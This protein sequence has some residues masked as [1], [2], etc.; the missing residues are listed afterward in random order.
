MADPDVERSRDVIGR[1]A[2]RRS[3]P[4]LRL[5][6]AWTD[7]VVLSGIQHASV[8]K[9][10]LALADLEELPLRL[11]RRDATRSSTTWSSS[12]CCDASFERRSPRDERWRRSAPGAPT[13]TIYYTRGRG[14]PAECSVHTRKGH[15][16]NDAFRSVLA[17]RWEERAPTN[18][19][20]KISL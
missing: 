17:L 9:D 12:A 16:R 4:G 19:R 18:A 14:V 15:S 13:R 10:Q 20:D 11:P 7:A 1:A 2:Q 5:D 8:G 6:A 3:H